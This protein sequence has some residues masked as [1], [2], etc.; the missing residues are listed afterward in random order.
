MSSVNV[1]LKDYD[2]GEWLAK[3]GELGIAKIRQQTATTNPGEL[4]GLGCS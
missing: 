2:I 1:L 4:V 3:L